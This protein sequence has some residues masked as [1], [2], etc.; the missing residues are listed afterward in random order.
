M[1]GRFSMTSPIEQIQL[2]FELSNMSELN[3][4]PR[5]NVA[6]SQQVFSIVSDGENKRGG[7]LKWGLVPSWAKDSRIGYKMINARSETVDTKP[8]FKNL[9]KRRRCLIVADGFYEWKNDGGQKQPFRIKMKDDRVFTFAGLWDRWQK[10]GETIHSCTI[11]TTEAND[12][13]SGIHDRM[14]V[15]LPEEK[16]DI[17]LNSTVQD[18]SYLKKLLKP[19]QPEEMTAFQVSTLVNSPKN[20]VPEIINSL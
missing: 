3:I 13:V 15:I 6:P 17:W 4:T 8:S 5:Y 12:V 16:Q 1:C 9:L 7:F 19:Y 18:S 2:A 14:P 20:D 10:D 11:I